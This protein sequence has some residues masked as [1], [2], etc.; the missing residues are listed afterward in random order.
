M[1][2][3]NGWQGIFPEKVKDKS[4]KPEWARIPFDNEEL[5]KFAEEHGYS[6][7][8][9]MDTFHQ[10]RNKLRIEVEQRSQKNMH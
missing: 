5:V 3:A 7:P 2:I 4:N 10:Y 9:A 1:T 8:G 6:K